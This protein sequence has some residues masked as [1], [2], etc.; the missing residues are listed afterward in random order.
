PVRETFAHLVSPASLSLDRNGQL[1][2][3]ILDAAKRAVFNPVEIVD[4]S[5]EGVWVAGLPQRATVITVGHEDVSDG[6]A[7]QVDFS[8]LNLFSQ[9]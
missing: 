6:Q 2:I 3:K 4:E 1:G 5:P 7:V 9:Y 8:E